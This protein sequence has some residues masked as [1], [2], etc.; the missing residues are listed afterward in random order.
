MHSM[1]AATTTTTTT[2]TRSLSSRTDVCCTDIRC[3]AEE[4]EKSRAK[5]SPDV[6]SVPRR[7]WL[8]HLVMALAGLYMAMLLS[9]W[10]T[11]DE[12]VLCIIHYGQ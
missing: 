8:F 1:L 11:A 10:G 2:T 3:L 7:V 12:Y 5:A 9:S 6:G 4:Y